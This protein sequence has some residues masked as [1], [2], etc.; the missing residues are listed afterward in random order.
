MAKSNFPKNLK[1]ATMTVWSPTVTRLK[2]TAFCLMTYLRP[3]MMRIVK[4][5]SQLSK[6][7]EHSLKINKLKIVI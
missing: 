3:K 4:M 2:V 7:S 6:L 5:K 1:V